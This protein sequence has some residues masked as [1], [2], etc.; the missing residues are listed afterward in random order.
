M[1][2]LTIALAAMAGACDTALHLGGQ[3]DAAVAPA[4]AEACPRMRTEPRR[5][6]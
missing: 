4:C 6:C 5:L 2:V 1:R 3:P